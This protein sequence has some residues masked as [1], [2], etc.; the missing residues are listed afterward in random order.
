MLEEVTQ[1]TLEEKKYQ[2]T[3]LKIIIIRIKSSSSKFL[4]D[5]DM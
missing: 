1:V 4:M 3:F 2:I 5:V